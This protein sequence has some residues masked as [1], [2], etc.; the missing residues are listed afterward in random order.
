MKLYYFNGAT[1][2]IVRIVINELGLPCEYERVDLS[3]GKVTE[4]GTD[5]LSINPRGMV[6]VL[7][8]DDQEYLT[9]SAIICQYLID[10]KQAT[11]LLPA[12]GDFKRYRVLE[13]VNFMAVDLHKL[14]TYNLLNPK[15][16][17]AIKAEVFIPIIQSKFSILDQ[18]LAKNKYLMGDH[19]MLPDAYLFVMLFWAEWLKVDLSKFSNLARY[20]SELKKRKSIVDSLAE[21]K[22]I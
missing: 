17:D 11:N 6:P 2:M 14:I 8:I 16:P 5:F 19:F 10:Q 22:F 12:A 18:A 7:K 15:L 20:F 1:S 4:S 21:E 13:W 3:A 9:E